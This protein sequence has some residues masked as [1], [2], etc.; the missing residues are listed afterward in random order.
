[1]IDTDFI[2]TLPANDPLFV[3]EF[4][5][6]LAQ[7]E[8][9]KLMR[10]FGLILENLDGLDNPAK[11]FVMRGVPHTLGMQVSMTRDTEHVP[12]RRRK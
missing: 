8:R 7:L 11:K 3:A 4:N 2:A 10:S 1:M 6:A 12:R 5:P 9:P